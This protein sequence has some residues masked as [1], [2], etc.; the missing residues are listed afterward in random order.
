VAILSPPTLREKGVRHNHFGQHH[1]IFILYN[2]FYNTTSKYIN[3]DTCIVQ[4]KKLEHKSVVHKHLKITKR[5]AWS[6]PAATY[7]FPSITQPINL[8]YKLTRATKWT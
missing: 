1:D 8:E 4:W 7:L 5:K 3:L 6:P 2:I